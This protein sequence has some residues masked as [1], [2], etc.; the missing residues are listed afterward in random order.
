MNKIFGLTH[1]IIVGWIALTGVDIYDK[2]MCSI[3]AILGY[4]YAYRIIGKYADDL[5]YNSTLMSFTHWLIRTIIVI[6]IM[7]ATRFFYTLLVNTEIDGFLSASICIIVLV[8]IAE[9]A[10]KISGLKKSYW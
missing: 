8:S 6:S 2:I 5:Y 4:I 9:V 3:I 7:L 1:T 10:K